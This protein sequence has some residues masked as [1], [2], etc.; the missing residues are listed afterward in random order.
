MEKRMLKSP[1][2]TGKTIISP[3]TVLFHAFWKAIFR[4]IHIYKCY[5][6]FHTDLF[7][8]MNCP[9]LSSEII[10]VVKSI[11]NGINMSTPV[12]LSLLLSLYIFFYLFTFTLCLNWRC[13]LETACSKKFSQSFVY[14]GMGMP[15][16][17]LIL[18]Y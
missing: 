10:F 4:F 7:T 12:F 9:Y 8:V 15:F 11:L 16:F 14:M 6:S 3:L 17:I 2:T 13:L 5:I 18:E 1:V